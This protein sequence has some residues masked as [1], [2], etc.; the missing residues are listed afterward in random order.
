MASTTPSVQ[1]IAEALETALKAIPDIRTLPY[2]PDSITPPIALINIDDV[3]YH[4]AFQGGDVTHSFTVFLI[5]GRIVDQAAF[6][7]LEGFM[8]QKGANSPT[9]VQGA[10]EADQTLGGVVSTLV[11]EKSGPVAPITVPGEDV[12]YLS[13]PFAVTVHA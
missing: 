13:V 2:L 7:A 5:V 3:E 9:S 4:G 8:S 1:D 12:I 11:V 10:I 6:A